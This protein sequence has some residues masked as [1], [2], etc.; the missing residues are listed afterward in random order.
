M[1]PQLVEF[2]CLNNANGFWPDGIGLGGKFPGITVC[3]QA[4]DFHSL[5]NITRHL[6]RTLP[7]RPRRPQDNDAFTFHLDL[8]LKTP[9]TPRIFPHYTSPLWSFVSCPTYGTRMTNRM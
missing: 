2:R 9:V 5:W 6:E 8:G 1:L 7:D 4:N 3:R